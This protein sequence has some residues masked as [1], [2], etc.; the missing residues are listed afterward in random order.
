MMTMSVA[1]SSILGA[2][3]VK[4]P[5]DEDL[6]G[7]SSHD[8]LEIINDLRLRYDSVVKEHE[9][10]T[11]ILRTR[12]NDLETIL[13]QETEA[14][15][16]LIKENQKLRENAKDSNI[17]KVA[18]NKQ[19]PSISKRDPI[20]PKLPESKSG[21]EHGKTEHGKTEHGKTEHGKIEPA[22]TEPVKVKIP[23][24]NNDK[25]VKRPASEIKPAPI[26]KKPRVPVSTSTVAPTK[27]TR[28]AAKPSDDATANGRVPAISSTNHPAV[29]HT[30]SSTQVTN[31][32]T[33]GSTA[34]S[35][36]NSSNA[37]KP[38]VPLS[39]PIVCTGTTGAGQKK[40]GLTHK[41]TSGS[42]SKIIA[43]YIHPVP[44][45]VTTVSAPNKGKNLKTKTTATT[46][47]PV[48]VN[49]QHVE[50]VSRPV[51]KKEEEICTVDLDSVEEARRN[52]SII[53]QADSCSHLPV[54]NASVTD[55]KSSGEPVDVL[56]QSVMEP[57]V[58]PVLSEPVD[59]LNQSVMEPSVD[60]LPHIEQLP[61]DSSSSTDSASDII[62]DSLP[63]IDQSMNDLSN[64]NITKDSAQIENPNIDIPSVMIETDTSVSDF[65]NYFHCDQPMNDFSVDPQNLI[66]KTCETKSEEIEVLPTVL[67]V[68]EPSDK[69]TCS[70]TVMDDATTQDISNDLEEQVHSLS[71]Q[72][73]QAEDA[74]PTSTISISTDSPNMMSTSNSILNEVEPMQTEVPEAEAKEN[75][76]NEPEFEPEPEPV[77][78]H[79]LTEEIRIQELNNALEDEVTNEN[80]QLQKIEEEMKLFEEPLCL[81]TPQN[82]NFTTLN[83]CGS[84]TSN[85]MADFSP[86]S[87]SLFSSSP[88]VTPFERSPSL[89]SPTTPKTAYGYDNE[90]SF[91]N[92]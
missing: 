15:A 16:E 59:V 7:K 62:N 5:L 90:S 88:P 32:I 63:T 71:L 73:T 84:V 85:S 69:E 50:D 82:L 36:T 10:K 53:I 58:E 79:K 72:S 43:P 81:P 60:S 31:H 12:L 44:T 21:P 47:E 65:S 8:L 30:G 37:A 29:N 40:I 34:A 51:E 3:V 13:R 42:Q 68:M 52:L 56:N 61:N 77:L 26:T 45:K 83:D 57:S 48:V 89:F 20:K 27:V 46:V 22:K 80:E 91:Y 11:F 87:P 14:K 54:P 92:F 23:K 67:E 55:E 66:E 49:P 4:F 35:T 33:S 19:G 28:T 18:N 2:V 17:L 70:D 76:E 1:N 9:E 74:H 25:L 75:M 38:R 6:S 41:T 86:Q 64:S 39:R 78:E 24:E